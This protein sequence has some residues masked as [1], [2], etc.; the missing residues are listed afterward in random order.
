M[1]EGAIVTRYAKALFQAADE[2]SILEKVKSDTEGILLSIKESAEFNSF[3]KS[4][5]IKESEKQR[6]FS[7][8]FKGKVE[9]ITL[10]FFQLLTRNKRELYLA[11]VCRQFLQLY[12]QKQGIKE[13]TIITAKALSQ[14]HRTE[15]DD[16]IK[17]KLKVNVDLI[18]HIDPKILGGFKLRIG[19][20]QIDA[21][22]ST[23]LQTIRKELI[24]SK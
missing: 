6:I 17:K 1:N 12:K 13:A 22:V 14:E 23:K 11:S 20:Q 18:E 9:N 2:E 3:L 24:N 16:Y 4:P 10:T 15:I 21:S 19:D 8:I 5:V 7:E